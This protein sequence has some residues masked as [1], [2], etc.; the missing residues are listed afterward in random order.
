MICTVNRI[1]SSLNVG[2]LTCKL[3][4]HREHLANCSRGVLN[5]SLPDVD[6]GLA[7]DSG[8]VLANDVDGRKDTVSSFLAE[9][10]EERL[11]AG[12]RRRVR[13]FALVLSLL[14]LVGLAADSGNTEKKFADELNRAREERK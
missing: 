8:G 14:V 6:G 11:L 5:E 2:Y 10:V 7:N 13:L 12:V 1:V 4:E 9:R 3:T